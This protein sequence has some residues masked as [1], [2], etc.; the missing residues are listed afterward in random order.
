[1]HG[2]RLVDERAAVGVQAL[3]RVARA[4]AIRV[5]GRLVVH[6]LRTVIRQL[7]HFGQRG[8]LDR[9]RAGNAARIGGHRAADVGVDVDALRLERVSDRDRGEIGS[10]A[11]RAS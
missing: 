2:R 3:D 11:A 7:G 9:A 5:L 10:A 8:A 1:M 6:H 4:G